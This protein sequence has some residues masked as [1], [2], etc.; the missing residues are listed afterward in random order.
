MNSIQEQLDKLSK[1]IEFTRFQYEN[2]FDE[3]MIGNPQ[4]Q[5]KLR[6][7]EQQRR[8]LLNSKQQEQAKS[9][10]IDEDK[11]PTVEIPTKEIQ[12]ELKKEEPKSLEN[13]DKLPIIDPGIS[14]NIS[15][16]KLIYD[17]TMNAW[18]IYCNLN[19]NEVSK[20]YTVDKRKLEH[21]INSDIDY[22]LIDALEEFDNDMHT[23]LKDK[24]TRGELEADVM[25]DLRG[26]MSLSK[27]MLNRK[28]KRIVK[29]NAKNQKKKNGSSVFFFNTKRA[30]KSLSRTFST[31]TKKAIVGA[32]I[33]GTAA[34]ASMGVVS[35]IPSSSERVKTGPVKETYIG[36]YKDKPQENEKIE[37][38]LNEQDVK[39][40]AVKIP[41]VVDLSEEADDFKLG[42]DLYLNDVMLAYDS[43]GTSPRV[44]TDGLNFDHYKLCYIA[45][46]K[47]K[48]VVYVMNRNDIET[49]KDKTFNELV[50]SI[51][52]HYGDV[53][54]QANCDGYYSD[55]QSIKNQ[56]WFE[57]N[58][59]INVKKGK[60]R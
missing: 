1:E 15:N 46:L 14:N 58:S 27:E 11:E 20:I 56:G 41:P 22:T 53:E 13:T 12:E 28:E 30:K 8:Q 17:V 5:N 47:D 2:S 38:K 48:K 36:N 44:N 33:A 21:L 50:E 49:Y 32:A 7:L 23:A 19:N 45:I 37:L 34:V 31:K 35:N 57:L 26:I 16:I 24:Y 51:R 52:N 6:L 54:I 3:N 42:D 4:L 43:Y 55:G 10:Q 39:D 25:Y 59:S 60:I 9:V 18:K 40:V 29:A